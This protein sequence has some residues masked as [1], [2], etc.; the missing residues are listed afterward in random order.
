VWLSA[1]LITCA[2]GLALKLITCV[3]VVWLSA[4]LLVIKILLADLGFHPGANTIIILRVVYRVAL[5]ETMSLT[6]EPSSEPL[7]IYDRVALV[8]RESFLLTTNW[9]E[10]T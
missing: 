10:S 3:Q 4:V 2:D 8:E 9:S 6:Y 1:V 5:V 7:H